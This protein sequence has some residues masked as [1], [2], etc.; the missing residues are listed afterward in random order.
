MGGK[1]V[2]V[3]VALPLQLGTP[4]SSPKGSV[5][6]VPLAP[7]Q[8]GRPGMLRVPLLASVREPGPPVLSQI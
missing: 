2:E 3:A 5:S 7:K 4:V 6:V 8:R 1:R